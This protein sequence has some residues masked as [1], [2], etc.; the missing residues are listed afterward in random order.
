MLK[1]IGALIVVAASSVYGFYQAASYGRRLEQIKQLIYSLKRLKTDIQ[2]GLTPLPDAF[3]HISTNTAQPFNQFFMRLSDRLLQATAEVAFIDIWEE[4]LHEMWY[5][6]HLKEHHFEILMQLGTVLG[7]SDVVDQQQHLQTAIE[8]FNLEEA[9]A[10]EEQV[11][12]ASLWRSLGALLG[13]T[14]VILLV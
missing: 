6:T 2:F 7:T 8:R 13:V 11:K 4:E 1:L 3:L 10:S 14:L 9:V 5:E 12:Y